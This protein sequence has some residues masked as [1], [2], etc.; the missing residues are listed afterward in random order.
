MVRFQDHFSFFDSIL[1][2]KIC[3]IILKKVEGFTLVTH[4]DDTIHD[5]MAPCRG[6]GIEK[7]EG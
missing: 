3:S 2:Y 1:T 4:F 5:H 7:K 6:F